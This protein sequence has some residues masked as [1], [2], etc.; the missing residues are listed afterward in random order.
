MDSFWDCSSE[1]SAVGRRLY[2]V[3][4]PCI[5]SQGRRDNKAAEHP[6]VG[7]GNTIKHRRQHPR[8]FRG[9]GGHGDHS[10]C[11]NRS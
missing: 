3:D 4:C 1:C 11:Q 9:G 2:S 10:L 5:R 8:S 6:A 7:Q